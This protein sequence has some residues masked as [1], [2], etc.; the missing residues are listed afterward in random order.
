MGQRFRLNTPPVVAETLDGETTIVDL[1]HGTYY[2]LNPSGSFIWEHLV[3]GAE[4]QEIAAALADHYELEPDE[5]G[6][7]V[8]ALV[9]ELGERE[10]VVPDAD[11]AAHAKL[12]GNGAPHGPYAPPELSA[13]TDMQELLLLDPVHE[14]D[15]AGWPSQS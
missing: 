12:D 8:D 7:A 1:K 14:V 4:P 15:E 13:F 2:A 10:L 11:G 9:A 6:G 5:A 3:A